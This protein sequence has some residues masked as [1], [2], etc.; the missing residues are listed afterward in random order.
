MKVTQLM[1]VF[2]LGVILQSCAPV[3]S[4]LQSARTVG[5]NKFEV[6]PSFSSVSFNDDG[7]TEGA[8]NHIGLQGAYGITSRF[9]LRFRYEHIWLKGE[10]D[11]DGVNVLGIGPK[12]SL[13]ENKVAIY[14]P[15]GRA[16]DEG[17][18]DTWQWQPTLLFTLP[19]IA[20]K[21]DVNLSPKYLMTLCKECDDYFALNLGL[22]ISQ[23]FSKWS[24][25]PEYGILVQP[26]GSG[27]YSHFSLGA[28]FVFGGKR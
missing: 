25:R 16:I 4:E 13:I 2:I 20:D 6:T 27:F 18:E 28:S 5:K 10:E 22:S 17:S 1:L 21:L 11:Y 3:F 26:D 12:F 19:V 23:D 14:A 15:I 8:Q 24:L 7:E 9:D